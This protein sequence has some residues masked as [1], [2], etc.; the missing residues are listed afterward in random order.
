VTMGARSGTSA[1]KVWGRAASGDSGSGDG[2]KLDQRS[3][4][5]LFKG[6]R[7]RAVVG[8]RPYPHLSNRIEDPPGV[9]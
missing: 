2:K 1:M 7:G 5:P 6:E 9:I 3:P 8:L 4:G